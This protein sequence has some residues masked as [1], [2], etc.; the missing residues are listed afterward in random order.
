MTMTL[1]YPMVLHVGCPKCYAAPGE[2]CI[3]PSGKI[4]PIPHLAR[5]ELA[6]RSAPG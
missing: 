6:K 1:H 5:Q 4:I 3:G 2:K